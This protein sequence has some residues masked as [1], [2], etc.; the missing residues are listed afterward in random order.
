[1]NPERSVRKWPR[2]EVLDICLVIFLADVVSGVIVPTYPLYAEGLGAAIGFIALVAAIGGLTRLAASIPVGL[3]SDIHGRR[4][5]LLWGMALFGLAS[6]VFGLVRAPGFL[7]VPTILLS[8]A[9]LATFPM[10]VAYVADIVGPEERG[11]AIA[12]YSTAMGAGFAAGPG[13]GGWLAGHY[14]FAVMYDLAAAIALVGFLYAWKRLARRPPQ[15][16]D[17]DLR[18]ASVWSNA[19]S[20]LGVLRHKDIAGPILCSLAF[21]VSFNAAI[22]IF[23]PVYLGALGYG[24]TAVGVVF[25]VRGIG[26]TSTRVVVGYVMTR[27]STGT[28]M[29]LAALAEMVIIGLMTVTTSVT[30]LAGLLVVEGLAFGVQLTASQTQIAQAATRAERGAAASAYGMA[31][32]LGQIGGAFG[33]GAVGEASG[34]A[35]VFGVTGAFMGLMALTMARFSVPQHPRTFGDGPL[36]TEPAQAVDQSSEEATTDLV[37]P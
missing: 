26:S 20:S 24:P 19:R 7:V 17:H 33:L 18:S 13:I 11:R 34:T 32:V 12:L 14:G 15:A 6:L 2:R 22:S 25:M 31:G 27:L 3:L 30:I 5:V 21:G 35:A 28:A 23:V 29:I 36:E 8:F 4:P 10:G 9:Q 37:A 16:P 1:V